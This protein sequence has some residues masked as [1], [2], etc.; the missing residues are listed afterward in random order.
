MEV[1][2]KGNEPLTTKRLEELLKSLLD[3]SHSTATTIVFVIDALDECHTKY[4]SKKLLA[5]LRGL[6]QGLEGLY[7]LISSRPHV[8]VGDYFEGSIQ[9][10]NCVQ[11]QAKEDMTNFIKSQIDSKR[12]DVEWK[13]SIFCK[14]PRDVKVET[15]CAK[16]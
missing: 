15:S 11:P 14:Y 3:Y 12:G 6:Q 13:K 9:V 16:L 7:F 1:K 10:F 8:N 2:G 4:D 5:F